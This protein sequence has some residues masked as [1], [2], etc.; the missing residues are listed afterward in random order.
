MSPESE[1]PVSLKLSVPRGGTRAYPWWGLLAGALAGV[2][3]GHPL[4]MVV[5]NFQDSIGTH[6]PFTPLNAILHSYHWHM[7]PMMLLY[8]VSTALFGALL[9]YIFQR[10]VDHQLLVEMLHHEFELQVATL[11]HHYKNLAIG[12]RGFSE[13]IKHRIE[14]LN[15]YLSQCQE[16]ECPQC[17]ELQEDFASLTR[18]V[19]I[20]D[21]TAQRLTST[22]GQ[23]LS[24]LKALTSESLIP[25]YRDLYPFLVSA[26]GDLLELRFRNKDLRVDIDGQPWDK[27]DGAL[28]FTFE[29]HAMEVVLQNLLSNAMKFGDH[30]EIRVTETPLWVRVE[31]QDNGPGL[32]VAKLKQHLEAPAPR[33]EV[34]STHLGLIV[35]LHLMEKCGGRILVRSRPGAGATFFLEF[36][37][38]P[39]KAE[40]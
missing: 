29:P 16:Q 12:I 22:L 10:L 8:G 30:I 34:D 38:H 31:I 1:Q 24:F 9:G 39:L 36:P 19:D 27:S 4:S 14:K 2:F 6:L 18:S 23:E 40:R 13:R 21:D 32:E 7:W 15:Q 26:V 5:Q 28:A 37:Q 20:L 11:R 17:G 35:S 3:V 33:R 25:E